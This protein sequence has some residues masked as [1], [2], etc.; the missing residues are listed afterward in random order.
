MTEIELRLALAR[1]GFAPQWLPK[2]DLWFAWRPVRTGALGTGGWTWL[3]Y[4]SR[5]RCLGVTIYQT[6]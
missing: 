2:F 5:D 3:R 4:V 6:P 1:G